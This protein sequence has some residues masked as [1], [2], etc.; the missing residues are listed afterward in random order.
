[1]SKMKDTSENPGIGENT[2]A[3]PPKKTGGKGTSA[4]LTKMALMLSLALVLSVLE[5]WLLPQGILPLPGWKLGLANIAIL[6]TMYSVGKGS[7][8]KVAVFRSLILLAF[9]G[10]FIGFGFSLV[11][12]FVAGV[13][14]CFLS[15]TKHVSIFGV[16]IAGAAMHAIGQILVALMFT[17][18]FYILTYLPWLMVA[19][20]FAGGVIAFLSIPVIKALD[21]IG[22]EMIQ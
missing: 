1:M 3:Q 11:G 6:V 21:H 17:K 18:T 22:N 10:N 9:S 14:M 19:S 13:T 4:R 15:E 16:S 2:T 12:G 8:L 7:A 5:A 20:A